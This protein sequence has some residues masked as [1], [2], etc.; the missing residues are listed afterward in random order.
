MV[1]NVSLYE[2]TINVASTSAKLGERLDIDSIIDA[3]LQQFFE[4][5]RKSEDISIKGTEIPASDDIEQYRKNAQEYGNNQLRGEYTNK[6]TGE[7]ISLG[8]KGIKEVLHHDYKDIPHIQSVVAIPQI[9][10]NSIYIDTKKNENKNKLNVVSYDY[11]V[12]GLDINGEKYTVKAVVSNLTDGSRYYDHKLT[13]I[14]KVSLL[15]SI[16]ENRNEGERITSPLP[17]SD[18]SGKDTRLF[19]ILQENSS[20]IVDENG[21]P[22]VVYHGTNSEFTVFD[23]DE[24][25]KTERHMR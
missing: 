5:A 1:T 9:I 8:R 7:T 6:D 21:E 12:C 11:Y 18:F 10:E 19:S 22:M 16:N 20:K 2:N 25:G 14:E 17:Q 24:I 13:Q 15:D 23:K 4:S 3:K